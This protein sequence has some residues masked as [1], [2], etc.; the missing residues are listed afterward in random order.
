MIEKIKWVEA[1]LDDPKIVKL[2]A[3]LTQSDRNVEAGGCGCACGDS[4]PSYQT[5]TGAV[6]KS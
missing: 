5:G 2:V 3:R 4:G 6:R 1:K